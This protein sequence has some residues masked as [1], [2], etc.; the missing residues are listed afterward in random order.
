VNDLF[1]GSRVEVLS[2]KWSITQLKD[3]PDTPSLDKTPGS[4]YDTSDLRS[5]EDP[6]ASTGHSTAPDISDVKEENAF[7]SP[8]T[9]SQCCGEEPLPSS[10]QPETD[11]LSFPHSTYP[12]WKLDRRASGH[13]FWRRDSST[14][15]GIDPKS[16]VKFRY[17]IEV[18]EF[19][20]RNSESE[21]LA[22][23]DCDHLYDDDDDDDDDDDYDGE[24]EVQDVNK[25]CV[26]TVKAHVS[27]KEEES[28]SIG[29]SAFICIVA[30]TAIVVMASYQWLLSAL[31][32]I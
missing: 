13:L 20:S 25:C 4:P 17:D 9:Y 3:V 16:R 11:V 24:V 5:V 31:S 2:C 32:L 10:L 14:L 26:S 1:E 18:R 8:P 29:T 12:H 6:T 19:E 28:S 15:N 21:D 7:E 30:V 27:V 23:D 22:D